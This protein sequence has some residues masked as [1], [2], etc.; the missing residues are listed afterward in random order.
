MAGFCYI[1]KQ[2]FALRASLR[3]SVLSFSAKY[4]AVND[5]L[6][7]ANHRAGFCHSSGVGL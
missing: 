4:M 1:I 7:R 6:R 2:V 3:A 5:Y